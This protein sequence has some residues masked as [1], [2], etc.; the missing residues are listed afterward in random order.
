M[1]FKR[2]TGQ[3]E[4]L[5]S[6]DAFDTDN[7]ESIRMD[8]GQPSYLGLVRQGAWIATLAP[9]GRCSK[10]TP[11]AQL[12]K[13]I[14]ESFADMKDTR[15][16][17]VSEMMARIAMDPSAYLPQASVKEGET[18]TVTK[19]A[20]YLRPDGSPVMLD[21]VS[22]CKLL[23][24]EGAKAAKIQI[25]GKCLVP[26]ADPK[27]L[28]EFEITGAMRVDLTKNH[29]L[30]WRVQ[31]V[32][33]TKDSQTGQDLVNHTIVNEG[34]TGEDALAPASQSASTTSSK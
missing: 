30:R 25:A 2:L 26:D 7:P 5:G 3:A 32:G 17:L 19:R 6:T 28:S 34:A 18:W 22:E 4:M 27:T 24:V 20:M 1:Q 14:G 11:D 21:E 16:K 15:V 8:D 31:M 23:K 33:R 12:A 13:A 29:C 9:L 10:I